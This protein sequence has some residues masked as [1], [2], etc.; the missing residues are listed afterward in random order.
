MWEMVVLMGMITWALC[1]ALVGVF[2]EEDWEWFRNLFR[3]RG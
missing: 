3:K 2:P 1:V